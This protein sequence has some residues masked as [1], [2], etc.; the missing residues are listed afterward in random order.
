MTRG[1]LFLCVANSARSQMAEA[2]ARRLAGDRIAIQSAGSAPSRVNPLAVAVLSEIGI[3]ASAQR[4]KSVD[5]IDRASVDTVIT[6]CSEEV[7]PVYLGAA[8]R[9]HWPLPDPAGREETE[10]ADLERF[11][12]VRDE[13]SRRIESF[14]RQEGVLDR[15]A[16]LDPRHRK[17][18]TSA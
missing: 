10:E 9:L 1:L 16:G 4:S 6:L 8:R 17:G 13:L 11:R 12:K 14:L 5:E 2:L 15:Q 3:D 18:T 7:C